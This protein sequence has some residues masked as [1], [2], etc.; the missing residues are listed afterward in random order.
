MIQRPFDVMRPLWAGLDLAAVVL[1]VGIGRSAHDHGVHLRGMVSTTWPFAGG[2]FVAWLVLVARRRNG[3]TLVSGLFASVVTV[4]VGMVIR[5]VAGQ[6]T[7][8][9]FILVATVFLG[10]SMMGWRILRSSWRQRRAGHDS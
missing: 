9:A 8:L 1:F 2:L 6:G 4:G 5:V 3:A 7:A 10:A